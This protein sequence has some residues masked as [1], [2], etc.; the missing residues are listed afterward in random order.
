MSGNKRGLICNLIMGIKLR[1]E[2]R[3]REGCTTHCAGVSPCQKL[4]DLF[5]ELVLVNEPALHNKTGSLKKH[6]RF[7]VLAIVFGAMSHGETCEVAWGWARWVRQ[8]H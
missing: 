2:V 1:L 7:L 6:H 3:A 5:R 8:T 4:T